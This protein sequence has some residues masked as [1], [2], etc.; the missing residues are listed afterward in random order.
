MREARSK[1]LR[2]LLCLEISS[3]T[4]ECEKRSVAVIEDYLSSSMGF[5][6]LGVEGAR[7]TDPPNE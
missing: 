7:M 4:L 1:R 3:S 2:D 6:V 5:R